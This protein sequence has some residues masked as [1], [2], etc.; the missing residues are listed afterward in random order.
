MLD[1]PSKMMKIL[2][3]EK[4]R[5]GERKGGKKEKIAVAHL[6][7]TYQVLGTVLRLL[8]ELSHL[9]LSIP[10]WGCDS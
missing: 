5:G 4:K 8:T 10:L 1:I 7:N 2:K 9:I 3:E 6:W